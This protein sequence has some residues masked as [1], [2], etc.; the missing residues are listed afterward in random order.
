MNFLQHIIDRSRRAKRLLIELVV[1]VVVAIGLT[2]SAFAYAPPPASNILLILPP[3]LVVNLPPLSIL[4]PKQIKFGGQTYSFATSGNWPADIPSQNSYQITSTKIGSDARAYYQVIIRGFKKAGSG[5][6]DFRI[7][8][9]D[10]QATK[11]KF[12]QLISV[13]SGGNSGDTSF[14]AASSNCAT[15]PPGKAYVCLKT[16]SY[17]FV[18]GKKY[19]QALTQAIPATGIFIE[20]NVT[21]KSL[22]NFS[23]FPNSIAVG[24][25]V[26]VSGG[27]KVIGYTPISAQPL[28]D[29]INAKKGTG[30]SY[31]TSGIA[32]DAQWNLNSST[33]AL[34]G[35]STSFSLPPEGKLWNVSGASTFTLDHL[36]FQGS[37]TLVFEGDVNIKNSV[38]CLANTRLA[39]VATG[40]ITFD[41]TV[42]TVACGAYVST[43]ADIKFAN[44]SKKHASYAGIFIAKNNI[45]LPNP[46]LLDGLFSINYDKNYAQNPTVLLKELIKL[47]ISTNS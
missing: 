32:A 39:I 26:D 11:D 18:S 46:T 17:V 45:T 38:A 27:L 34:D 47:A 5:V 2:Q 31:V 24:Q 25:A 15:S 41:S 19:S 42:D 6:K 16:T 20:G 22:N 3:E 44:P 33:Q 40:T 8:F 37:G 10:S 43:G 30:T 29:M 13:L 1:M 7:T 12:N 14:L 21:A 23:I 35:P 4:P 28:F 36:T 9:D